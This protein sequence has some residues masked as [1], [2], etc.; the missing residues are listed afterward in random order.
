MNEMLV[1][2]DKD[3]DPPKGLSIFIHHSRKEASNFGKEHL[4]YGNFLIIKWSIYRHSLQ[5]KRFQRYLK[6]RE[7]LK[8]RKQKTIHAS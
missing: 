5:Y 8:L 1:V 2:T 6:Y 7:K 3:K 4:G